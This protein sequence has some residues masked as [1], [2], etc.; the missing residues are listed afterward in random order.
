MMLNKSSVGVQKVC[1]IILKEEI[2]M[3]RHFRGFMALDLFHELYVH[4]VFQ[5]WASTKVYV[6]KIFKNWLSRNFISS[7]F[8]IC[9]S[10]EVNVREIIKII[11]KFL[12]F[13]IF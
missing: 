12:I 1:H 8:E 10:A 3:D 7:K 11:S 6:R 5:N 4:Q 2:F 9:P 13:I